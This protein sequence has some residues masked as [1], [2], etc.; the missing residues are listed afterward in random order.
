MRDYPSSFI[1]CSPF[2]KQFNDNC[3]ELDDINVSQE[4]KAAFDECERFDHEKHHFNQYVLL[5]L[6]GE[7]TNECN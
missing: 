2:F 3:Y 7:I 4:E 6:L 5:D 1:N